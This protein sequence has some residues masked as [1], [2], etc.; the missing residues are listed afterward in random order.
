MKNIAFLILFLLANCPL[1][2]QVG[3]LI[4]EDNFN[5][6]SLD[7]T[8]WS[9]E[10]GTGVNGDWGTGQLDRATNRI[11][12]VHFQRNV[13]GAEDGCLVITTR[14]ERYEDRNYTSGRINTAGKASWGPGCRIVARVFPRD[15]KY[16]G[17]GFAFWMM[18]SE[19][20]QGWSWLM[21]PQG[22]EI[23][24]M[25]YVGAIPYHNLGG[26]HFA[27][28]WENN[29]WQSWN[30]GHLAAYYSYA[31]QAVPNPSEPGY[32]GYPPANDDPN[33]GSAGFH[34]YGIDWYQDRMEFFVD[35]HVYHIHYL[36]DGSAFKKDGKDELAVLNFSGKRVGVSEYSNHFSEWRPFE[37]QMFA[38]LSAGVGG[39]PQ[40]YGGVVGTEAVF[41]C[42]VFIDWVRVYELGTVTGVDEKENDAGFRIF[43]NPAQGALNIQVKEPGHYLVRI[44]DVSGKALIQTSMSQ[45]ASIDISSL[46]K[47]VYMVFLSDKRVAMSKKVLVL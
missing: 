46:T 24:I 19:L 12:N 6:D 20:P 41:P 2:A 29:Q 26:V 34:T 14:K 11:E 22:G 1:S 13:P 9:F 15:V 10:T 16:P 8:K 30:H 43:P 3:K 36:N 44:A 27:W 17:Q 33:A 37:H 40:T 28:S 4:W 39:G 18:P 25:E 42:S 35:D 47:G 45:S 38:I 31:H 21:W 32:G 23:D 5:Q 7:L